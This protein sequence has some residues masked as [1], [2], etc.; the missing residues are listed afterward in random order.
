VGA[1]T[2]ADRRGAARVAGFLGSLQDDRR[3]VRW[4][5]SKLV[6]EYA[7]HNGHADIIR[8]RIDGQ[9]GE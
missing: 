2:L 9:T 1:G 4:N 8:E 3:S 6:G 7:R 5:L